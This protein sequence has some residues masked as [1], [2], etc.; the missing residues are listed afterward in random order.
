ME[1]VFVVYVCELWGVSPC[2]EVVDGGCEFGFNLVG[3]HRLN[4]VD[5]VG[6][7]VDGVFAVEGF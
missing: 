3:F 2:F 1:L 6:G 5:F 7:G 4:A